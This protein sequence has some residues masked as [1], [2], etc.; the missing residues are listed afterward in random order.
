MYRNIHIYI[1]II[2]VHLFMKKQKKRDV[3]LH[4]TACP[5]GLGR[6]ALGPARLRG[7]RAERT[8]GAALRL[9]PRVHGTIMVTTWALKG[10][11]YHDFGAYV[12][13]IVVLGPFGFERTRFFTGPK[14]HRIMGSLVWYI[15]SGIEQMVYG[16]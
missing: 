6:P 13:T 8:P 10:L 14:D 7:R 11:L 4:L 16:I 12:Y 5:R 2:Q 1:Y 15:V 3:H 9:P